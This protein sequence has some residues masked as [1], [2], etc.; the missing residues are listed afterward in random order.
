MARKDN[1]EYFFK[2]IYGAL[3]RLLDDITEDESLVRGK[4]KFNNIRWQVGHM[5]YSAAIILKALKGGDVVPEKWGK[6]F[7]GG[8][9]F[10]DGPDS[11]PTVSEMRDVLYRAHEEM[12]TALSAIPENELYE[13][14]EI[15]PGCNEVRMNA[16]LF[17]CAHE[18]YH[19][20]QVA[21]LRKV[22]GRERSFG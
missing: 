8:A 10:K 13:K 22:L 19:C 7:G 17:L 15:L 12:Y 14:S 4:D 11:Y 6:I 5:A 21:N 9:E 18:F 3:M 20:G 2:S 16:I 1:L